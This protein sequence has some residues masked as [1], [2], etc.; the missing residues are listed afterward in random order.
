VGRS[1]REPVLFALFAVACAAGDDSY[2]MSRAIVARAYPHSLNAFTEGLLLIDG[3][4]YES[5]GLAGRSRVQQLQ[6][7][8]GAVLQSADVPDNIFGEGLAAVG[9]NLVQLSWRDGRAMIWNRETL[10]LQGEF[11]YTGEGWG[12]CFDGRVFVMSDGTDRL[13]LR[14]SET[15]ALISQVAVTERGAPL[16]GLNELECVDD[17]VL[18]NIWGHRHIVRI[19]IATGKVVQRIDT[20]GILESADIGSDLSRIDV[21]NGIAATPGSDRL[22]LTGKYWPNIFEVEVVPLLPSTAR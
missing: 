5:T 7:E 4:V 10:R 9:T 16:D 6:L 22:W 18:A 20:G 8:T 17:D 21:L 13:Q 12:L 3:Y 1:I 19:K 15:F 14:H 11:K 2:E